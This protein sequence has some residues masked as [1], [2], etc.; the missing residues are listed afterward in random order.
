MENKNIGKLFR[1]LVL[2]IERKKKSNKI[3]T[4]CY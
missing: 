2:S 1:N 3:E 4:E